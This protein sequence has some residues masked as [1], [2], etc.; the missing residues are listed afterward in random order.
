V[1]TQRRKKPPTALA[2][3]G[4]LVCSPYRCG[5]GGLVLLPELPEVPEPL[6]LELVPALLPLLIESLDFLW[7]FLWCFDMLWSWP[8][9]L[10]EFCPCD[11]LP[12]SWP[13]LE[14]LLMDPELLPD[15]PLWALAAEPVLLPL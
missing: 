12:W 7:C 14:P 5:G 11:M 2:A 1:G 15:C 4:F 10:V 8:E 3:D 13:E 6:G 9:L